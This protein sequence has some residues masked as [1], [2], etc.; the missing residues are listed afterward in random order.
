LPIF[1]DASADLPKAVDIVG[2]NAKLQ[3]PRRLQRRGRPCW[4][5]V[6]PQRSSCPLLAERLAGRAELRACPRA[7]RSWP[8]PSRRGWS[9]RS[10]RVDWETEFLDYILAVKIVD[11]STRLFPT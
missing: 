11:S 5:T 1:V 8:R 7:L 4:G 3:K 2:E 9:Q 6:P 10:V